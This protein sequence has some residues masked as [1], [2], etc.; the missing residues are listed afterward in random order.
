MLT[1]TFDPVYDHDQYEKSLDESQRNTSRTMDFGNFDDLV[2]CINGFRF[3]II[4]S[5]HL[6]QFGNCMIEADYPELKEIR[7]QP[8]KRYEDTIKID[9]ES[10]K[11]EHKLTYDLLLVDIEDTA[12]RYANLCLD[13][14]WEYEVY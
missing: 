4:G 13:S 8:S 1:K 12:K 2:F 3:K 14:D 5:V 7:I 9:I 10:F 11:L 6:S